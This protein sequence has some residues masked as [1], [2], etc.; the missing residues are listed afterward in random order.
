[1]IIGNG[2]DIVSIERITKLF[3]KY[4]LVF[5]RKILTEREMNKFN[6][7]SNPKKQISFL[8]NRFAAKESIT[9]ALGIG[10]GDPYN[11]IDI[12]ILNN[13]KGAPY[14]KFLR[15]EKL[16][17]EKYK[18]NLSISDERDYAIAFTVISM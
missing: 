16:I 13:R 2:V 10:I 12:E 3:K 17:N 1:M 8:A 11:F 4:G 18:F 15:H 9:K 6:G 14:V 5:T 7:F